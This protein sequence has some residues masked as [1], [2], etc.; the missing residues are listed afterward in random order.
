MQALAIPDSLLHNDLNVGNV[1]IE[2]SQCVFIDWSEAYVGN[3][4]FIFPH[5]CSLLSRT[6]DTSLPWVQ[7]LRARYKRPWQNLLTDAQMD[8]AFALTPLLAV[9]SCLYGRGYWLASP[10]RDEPHFQGYA[11]SLA[12]YMDRAAQ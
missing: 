5:L 7:H 12:R 8:R 10:E 11:R 4:F 3:P 1:L 6:E 9:L 2:E